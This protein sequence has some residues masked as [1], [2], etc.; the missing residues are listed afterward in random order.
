MLHYLLQE[1]GQVELGEINKEQATLV[2]IKHTGDW[3]VHECLNCRTLTHAIHKERRGNC[4]VVNRALLSDRQHIEALK[5]SDAFSHVFKLLV[6][7]DAAADVAA[8][9]PIPK[10]TGEN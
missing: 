8:P 5:N 3:L 2:Y 7:R 4:V 1:I 9:Q 10:F 6:D